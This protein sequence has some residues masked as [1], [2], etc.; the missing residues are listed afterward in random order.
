MSDPHRIRYRFDLPDGSSKTLD[1]LFDSSDF[2][3]QNTPPAEPPF[4]TQLGFNQCANCPLDVLVQRHCP[5]ALQM[6]AAVEP[7]EA[8]VSYDTVGVTVVQAER[9]VYVETTA[10]QA[11]SSVLGL[12]MATS[13]CPW[14]SHLRPMARF[15]LP[16][17]SEAETVYRSIS[18]FLLAREMGGPDGPAGFDALED[19]YENIH[20]VNR[21]MS[22]RLGAATRTDPARNALALLD[23]YT[24]LL[25]AALESSL[26]ELKPLFDAWQTKKIPAI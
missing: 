25:P 19:L 15:H 12:I 26:D 24:T 7:L 16:F 18:M 5:A 8:L 21:D 11:M 9:T 17:A 3:L 23:A 4:W 13:G 10:Q 1:F 22:R 6:A 20:V 2:K 14:T